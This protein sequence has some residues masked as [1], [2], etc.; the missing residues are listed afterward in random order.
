MENSEELVEALAESLW[1][2]WRLW[3]E[4]SNSPERLSAEQYWVL[5]TLE[6]ESGMTVSGLAALRG[7]TRAAMTIAT[8]RMQAS[9][10]VERLR[11]ADDQ[12]Q[13]IVRLTES[14]RSLWLKVSRERQRVLR[15]LLRTLSA[16]EQDTLARVARKMRE[17][18]DEQRPSEVL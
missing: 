17:L 13:V 16:D 11:S 14:G 15:S 6:R 1:Q 4:R 5:R 7:V 2:L 18:F 12:R 10:W 3:N 8:Q 9:G